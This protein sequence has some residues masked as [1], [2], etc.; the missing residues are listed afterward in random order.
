MRLP[1]G[2]VLSASPWAAFQWPVSPSR[3]TGFFARLRRRLNRLAACM[4]RLFLLFF[5]ADR[6]ER[7]SLGSG[8]AAGS[9]RPVGGGAKPCLLVDRHGRRLTTLRVSLTS[10]CNLRCRYCVPAGELPQAEEGEDLNFEERLRVVRL[11]VRLGIRRIKLTGGEPLLD[12]QVL[13]FVAACR[14]L[15]GVEELSMTT[16]GLRLAPLA[17]ALAEAGLS[18][19]TVSLD[20]LRADVFR[21]L[22]RGGRLDWVW[23]GLEAAEKAGLKPIKINCVPLREWNAH[24]VVELAALSLTRPWQ[25]RFIEYMPMVE[26]TGL[27]P[28]DGVPTPELKARLEAAFGPLEALEAT[29]AGPARVW[30]IPGARGSLGFISAVSDKFCETCDRLRLASDGFLRLCLSQPA[31]IALKPLLRRGA[32]EQELFRAV[33]DAVWDKPEGHDFFG[34]KTDPSI[35]MSRIGG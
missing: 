25:I 31:G 20:S 27:G 2:F 28:L 8:P 6:S 7:G 24:E 35:R 1:F 21:D 17:R 30:R 18:R 22:T 34:K 32:D 3:G 16:N 4:P 23:Q 15:A 33:L 19:V 29:P 14:S 26:G 9:R 13:P 11:L 5:S 10:R 12:P